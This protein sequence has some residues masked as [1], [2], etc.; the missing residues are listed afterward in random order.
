MVNFVHIQHIF[1]VVMHHFCN[2]FNL[3][4]AG[5]GRLGTK[6]LPG[7]AHFGAGSTSPSPLLTKEGKEQ[8]KRVNE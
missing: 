8:A 7:P 2:L 4:G 3:S 5:F 1:D 6:P